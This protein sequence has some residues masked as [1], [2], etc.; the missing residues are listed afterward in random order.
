M[1]TPTTCHPLTLTRDLAEFP[2]GN[3]PLREHHATVAASHPHSLEIHP[4]AWIAPAEATRDT[5]RVN[6]GTVVG[7]GVHTGIHTSIYPGRK[8]WPGTSTRPGEIVRCDLR[9]P[10]HP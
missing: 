4:E 6:F 2:V 7:D 1:G 9:N 8:L 10:S 5:G 3:R